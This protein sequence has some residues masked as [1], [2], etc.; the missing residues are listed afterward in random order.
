MYGSE[1]AGDECPFLVGYM[2]SY[3]CLTVMIISLSLFF[4]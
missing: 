3:Y 4:A 1:L 2:R